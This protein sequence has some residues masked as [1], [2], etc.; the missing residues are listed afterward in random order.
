M[1]DYFRQMIYYQLG[2][3]IQPDGSVK[4]WNGKHPFTGAHYRFWRGGFRSDDKARAVKLSEDCA[5]HLRV[6][7][8]SALPA[9]KSGTNKLIG[10]WASFGKWLEKTA[11]EFGLGNRCRTLLQK[12]KLPAFLSY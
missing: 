8:L 10:V 2:A 12:E 11:V 4:E 5:A 7:F 6:L 1:S 3:A 9:D